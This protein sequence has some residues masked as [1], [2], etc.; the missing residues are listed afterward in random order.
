MFSKETCVKIQN[1]HLASRH[2]HGRL[3]NCMSWECK[4]LEPYMSQPEFRMPATHSNIYIFHQ[5]FEARSRTTA[6]KEMMPG[7]LQ[8]QSNC[9][10]SFGSSIRHCTATLHSS[11]HWK[12]LECLEPWEPCWEPYSMFQERNIFGVEECLAVQV[13]FVCTTPPTWFTVWL[14]VQVAAHVR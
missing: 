6:C 1:T 13:K 12:A 11:K 14:E 7:C 10:R 4:C 3:R 9:N 5:C 2:K 8:E